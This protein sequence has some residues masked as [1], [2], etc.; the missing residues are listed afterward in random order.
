M[1]TYP[2]WIRCFTDN[3]LVKVVDG[4]IADIKQGEEPNFRIAECW[5]AERHSSSLVLEN[6]EAKELITLKL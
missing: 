4:Q 5:G 6:L 1:K 2:K 3:Q